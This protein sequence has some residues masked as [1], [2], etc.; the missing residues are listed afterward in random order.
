MINPAISVP[1]LFGQ[2]GGDDN[3]EFGVEGGFEIEVG[4]TS[5]L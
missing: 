4:V 3:D 2:K 1:V 5:V